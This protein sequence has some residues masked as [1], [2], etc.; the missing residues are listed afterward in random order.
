M[1]WKSLTPSLIILG[2]L[3]VNGLLRGLLIVLLLGVD[4]LLR[5]LILRL[6]VGVLVVHVRIRLIF[7]SRLRISRLSI[8]LGS[9]A[10]IVL[11][12]QLVVGVTI[13]R[14]TEI[15]ILTEAQNHIE[16]GGQQDQANGEANAL[17]E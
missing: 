4:R 5:L 7:R 8:L 6:Y 10:L 14:H 12:F 3:L 13:L 17:T 16:D 2:R 11:G 15:L 1:Q 9:F